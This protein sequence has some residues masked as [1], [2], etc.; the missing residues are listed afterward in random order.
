[1]PSDSIF[2]ATLYGSSISYF[3]GKLENYFR[4]KG[5]PY[6]LQALTHPTQ[7]KRITAKTGSS[8]MPAL[9]LADG[10]WMSDSTPIIQWFEDEYPATTVTPTDPLQRFFSLLL[11]DY[12]DEWL[13]RPAMHYRWHY[14]RGARFA[15]THL[16]E[17]IL[18]ELPLPKF[19]TRRW[20]TRRQRNGYTL[21]DGI[22]KDQVAGVEAIYLRTLDQLEAI[23][24]ERPFLLGDTP[25]LVDIGFSG[26]FF[27]HFGLDPVPAELMR[28][29]APAVTEWVARLW[30]TRLENCKGS[31]LQGIPDDWG[32][33]LDEIGG[34][35]LPYL[36]ANVE[37]VA[38]GQR[39]FDADIG[40]VQYRRARWSKYRVWCLQQLRGHFQALA[41]SDQ[42]AARVLLER[43]HCWE[44]LWR[45]KE[46]PIDDTVCSQLPFQVD[47][48]MIDVYD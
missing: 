4:I 30:N 12:A 31:L 41:S 33:I 43:H 21:G 25:S 1:M 35:Y 37:A 23:F 29:R 42:Q 18:T 39:R 16:T 11:E 20:I 47:V 40:G 28:Q 44:P 15:S 26:P 17:E 10:R 32:P 3:T 6:Q 22:T 46:L 48:K 36:C 34:H 8:Q 45:H 5:I 27:R 14:E 13:W 38:A 2:P 19:M 7:A 24:R 9:E